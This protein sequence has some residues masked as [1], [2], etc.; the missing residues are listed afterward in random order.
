KI[1]RDSGVR[2]PM[3]VVGTGVDHILRETPEPMDM[4]SQAQQAS[5]RF[6]HVSS[7]F[8][9]KGIDALI[10]AYGQAFR[11]SDD[12]VLVI[13]TFP[14]PH[15]DVAEQLAVARRADPDYPEVVLINRDVPQNQML[16]LYRFCHALVAPS[17]GEG[18]GMPMAEAMLF[19]LPVIV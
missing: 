5:F 19:D 1:L 18:F 4:P 8:P 15:N 17:R 13:K 11:K 9:R 7:C 6:L 12:V 2:L 10:A 16:W 3:A 14:N